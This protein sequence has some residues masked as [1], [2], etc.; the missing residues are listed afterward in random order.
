MSEHPYLLEF[1]ETDTGVQP[2]RRFID[3]ALTKTQRAA[4]IAALEEI[5]AREGQDVCGTPFGKQLGK[6]LFEFR[7]DLDADAV[8]SIRRSDKRGSGPTKAHEAI[9]LRVF[10]HAYGDK[11]I[12]LI[13]GYDKLADSKAQNREI[14]T[15]QKYLGQFKQQHARTGSKLSKTR[16]ADIPVRRRFETPGVEIEP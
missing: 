5:L 16:Q 2:C 3:K 15:A 7:L 12:L 14:Q 13:A 1:F 9:L 10:C 8:R 6:G 11:I 4:L